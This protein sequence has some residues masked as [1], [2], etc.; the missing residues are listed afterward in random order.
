VRILTVIFGLLLLAVAVTPLFQSPAPG[1]AAA[2]PVAGAPVVSGTGCPYLP[3]DAGACPYLRERA[4]R[5]SGGCPYAGTEART[6]VELRG[7]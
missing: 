1:T 3:A 6:P 7:I 5:V 4:G 2:C